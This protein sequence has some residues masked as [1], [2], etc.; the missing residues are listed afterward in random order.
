MTGTIALVVAAGTGERFGG[1][2]PKQYRTLL[3]RP[4][5]R[6]AVERLGG[7]PAIDAVCVVRRAEHGDLYAEISPRTFPIVAIQ[8]IKEMIPMPRRRAGGGHH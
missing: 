4:L 5:L 8:E 7:H 3:G 2:L 1:G 6:H